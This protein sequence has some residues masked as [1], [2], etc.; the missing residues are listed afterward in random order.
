MKTPSIIK[1]IGSHL[2]PLVLGLTAAAA[3][4]TTGPALAAG[5]LITPVAA[6]AQSY[7]VPDDRAP[8]H[9]IDGSDMTPNS[10]VTTS[11]TCGT[12]PGGNMWLSNGNQDTWITFDLGRV[13]TITGFHLWNY[14]ENSSPGEYQRGVRTAGIYTGTSLLADGTTYASAGAA[15]GTLVEEMTFTQA[16]GAGGY[17]GEDYLFATPVTT[18]YIQIYVTSNFGFDNYTGISEIRFIPPPATI[19]SFGTNVAWSSAVIDPVVD[20]AAAIAWTVPYGTVLATL[21]PEFTLSS[22]TCTDQTSGVTPVP[23]FD[24]DS[25]TYTVIDGGITNVYTVTVHVSPISTACDITAFD[26]NFP[27]SST[28]ITTTSATEGTV[29]VHV[30]SGTTEAQAAALAPTYTPSAFATCDQTNGTIPTPPLSLTT[31]VHYIV[32]AQDGSTTKD[33]TVTVT[34]YGLTYGAWTGDGDSGITSDSEY[35]VAVN[36]SGAAVTVNGVAFEASA[37][38]GANFL[39]EGAVYGWGPGGAPNVTGDSYTL[40]NTFIYGGNPR[41][42]TLTHLTPGATYE[43]SLFAFGFDAS[44]TTRIQTFAS[45]NERL[46]LDQDFYGLQDGIRISYRFV[47]DSSGSKVLTITPVIVANTFHISAL[48]N[49]LVS[50]APPATILSFGTN[51][52]RSSAVFGLPVGGAAAIAWTVP[53]A[54]VLADLAPEFTLSSGTCTD[55]TSGITPSPG[56]SAGPVTYTVTDTST[57]PVTVNVYTVTVTV[58][59]PSTACD[60][61]AFGTNVAGSGAIITTT[62]DTTGTVEW[63]VP[64]DT[65]VAALAPTYTLSEFATCDQTNSTIPTPALSL[66]TPV[67]YLVTAQDTGVSKD[68]TVTV[69]QLPPPPG[70]TSV[71]PV[72]WYDAAVGVTADSATGVVSAWADRSGWEHH[73]TTAS[74]TPVLAA[75]ELNSLPA[76]QFRGN[77]DWLDLTGTFFAKQQYIVLSAPAATWSNYGGF[78][79]RGAGRASNYLTENANT[80]F[81][82]NEYPLSVSRNGT[83]LPS[84]FSLAPIT[85]YML[86]KIT[87]NNGDTS[88]AGYQIGRADGYSCDWNVAE[89]IGYD[90]GLSVTDENLVGNYIATKYGLTINEVLPFT[91]ALTGVGTTGTLVENDEADGYRFE[92]GDS[93]LTVN[94]LGLYDA[95]N[96]D[97]TGTVGDGLLAEHRVSI[98]RE[99][100]GVLVARTTVLTTDALEGNFR[101]NT[102]TPVTLTANTGYVIAA[103]YGATGDRQWEGTDPA[104]WGVYDGISGLAGRY[105]S[106]GG[107]MPTAEYGIIMVGP[108]F[109]NTGTV[110]GSYDTW[111][112]DNGIT[113]EPATGDFDHDGLTNLMEYALGKDPTASSQP[114]G[115]L[116][117]KVIT[118]T[119][120]TDAI[121][122]GDV[123]WGIQTSTT[124]AA[125]SWTTVVTQAAGN[126]DATISYTLPNGVVGGKV[127]ARLVVTT[128]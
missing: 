55:Q 111:A 59:P 60:I 53:Y 81:H 79:G 125:D 75:S 12:G 54:T 74:G 5:G 110:G 127:F 44:P 48:A 86:V 89:I 65:Q 103:D 95:P 38:S 6:T 119:K 10:P 22:G 13:Q 39:I 4:S 82:V 32:T 123:S 84:P 8:V 77:N 27:G 3:F 7:F 37:L 57:D 96:N 42:V 26:A 117:G 109:G 51:V 120:G 68:Y 115:E 107:G 18:R 100:D 83:A 52:A 108:N 91:M 105:G 67:H 102:I 78:L 23:G 93:A 116:T 64:Y 25:V 50:D 113:G 45:G 88:A 98:W 20:G 128:P 35:T 16:P 101:G 87:V 56:F 19:P 90:H 62:G 124:L 126:P 17:A 69:T 41:T 1:P 99:S 24:A 63:T 85:E 46:V 2:K 94:W 15:W 47:A 122:N 73:G 30:P 29:V 106:P 92:T 71:S 49:R 43:T 118:F 58:A 11:S 72:C 114:A 112:T 40:A 31:P 9:A 34:Y 28:T 104:E 121:A 76:V 97:A 70:G 61:T 36:C 21:A 80:V 66:T 33:Y 14:N